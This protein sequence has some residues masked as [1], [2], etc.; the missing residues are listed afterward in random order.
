M[1]FLY[2]GNKPVVFYFGIILAA[3]MVVQFITVKIGPR[4]VFRLHKTMGYIIFIVACVHA[5][6]GLILYVL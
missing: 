3:L 6:T 1:S 4:K 5:I 2:L